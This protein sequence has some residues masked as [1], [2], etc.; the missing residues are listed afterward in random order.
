M[1]GTFLGLAYK[2]FNPLGNCSVGSRCTQN[3]RF[4]WC[5]PL[6]HIGGGSMSQTRLTTQGSTGGRAKTKPSS[7][8]CYASEFREVFEKDTIWEEWRLF[9]ARCDVV[10]WRC[11]VIGQGIPGRG[12]IWMTTAGSWGNVDSL[13]FRLWFRGIKDAERSVSAQ[14]PWEDAWTLFDK[15]WGACWKVLKLGSDIHLFIHSTSI[16][17]CQALFWAL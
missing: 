9:H 10:R 4:S 5:A 6:A 16:Y 13:D 3:P 1:T 14:N 12:G 17:S 8:R 7:G 15:Q 11:C 2:T